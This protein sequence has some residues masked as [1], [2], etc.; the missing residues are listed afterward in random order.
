[1]FSDSSEC[2]VDIRFLQLENNALA[3]VS[4]E[5][6]SMTQ[7]ANQHAKA[8]F[9]VRME[10][11]RW[12]SSLAQELY[13]SEQGIC[14]QDGTVI[15]RG[16]LENLEVTS[17][18]DYVICQG[19]IVSGSILM[20]T[21]P[22]CRS[23]QNPDMTW[24]QILETVIQAYPHGFL[25]KSCRNIDKSIGRP[26]IQYQETDWEFLN[27]I[28][29][30]CNACIYPDTS[31]PW[32]RCSLG[33]PASRKDGFDITPTGYTRTMSRRFYEEGGKA[34]GRF[35]ADF[36]TITI[37]SSKNYEVGTAVRYQRQEYRIVEKEITMQHEEVVFTYLLAHEAYLVR[38]PQYNEKVSGISL[39]GTVL[40]T[41]GETVKLH[42]D[43]D[44]EQDKATAY[45]Y[46][47][48]PTSNN[49]MYLMPQVG[50]KAILYIPNHDEQNAEA[51]G[52]V[53]TNGGIDSTC[54]PMADYQNRSLTT[55]HGKKLYLN[56][57]DM[58]ASGAGGALNLTDGDKLSFQSTSK[59][60]IKA[61]DAIHIRAK[62]VDMSALT[63][64]RLMVAGSEINLNNLHDHGA[65]G[66]VWYIGTTSQVLE[67][68]TQPRKTNTPRGPDFSDLANNILGTVK[69]FVQGFADATLDNLS[70]GVLS[71]EPAQWTTSYKAGRLAG[72]VVGMAEGI[73]GM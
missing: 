10:A 25:L 9:T 22:R 38:R 56:P 3:G 42:L 48:V 33:L 58:G 17:Q 19:T 24:G 46:S 69:Q 40:A 41:A 71:P 13:N 30:R 14:T 1:M 5:A 26:I 11:D 31:Q 21:T 32:A 61:Q 29:S 37:K 8:D 53:R 20:D 35:K 16:I 65:D 27:R 49:L 44:R 70:M 15:F 66:K 6:F 28:A 54:Q 18:H 64:I 62:K 39:I 60:T 52:C 55:E 50:T 2:Q 12:T 34:A 7:A 63:Q 4:L 59:V 57:G 67:P 45:P 43:I 47:W 68:I 51:I 36:E 73:L 72:D 23:F